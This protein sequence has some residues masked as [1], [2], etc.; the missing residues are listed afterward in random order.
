V[1]GWLFLFSWC[2]QEIILFFTGTQYIYMTK[3][4]PPTWTERH[5]DVMLVVSYHEMIANEIE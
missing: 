1:C 5:D 3:L 4:K 2:V